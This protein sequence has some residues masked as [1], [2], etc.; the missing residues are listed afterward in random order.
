MYLYQ[1]PSTGFTIPFVQATSDNSNDVI[2]FEG[3]LLPQHSPSNEK[4]IQFEETSNETITKSG[5]LQN[6]SI[7][8]QLNQSQPLSQKDVQLPK[9]EGNK[10]YD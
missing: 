6:P 4:V 1:V 3:D 8:N 7:Q 9:P 10:K 2:T 5:K